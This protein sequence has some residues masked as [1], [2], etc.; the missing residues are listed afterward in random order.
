[1]KYAAG[2]IGRVFLVRFE[3]GDDLIEKIKELAAKER[4]SLASITL[5]GALK[6]GELVTGPKELVTPADANWSGFGDGREV[7]AFG[8]IVPGEKGI[9][10]HLHGAFG[11]GGE[12]LTGC[13]RKNAEVFIT[14]DCIVTEIDGINV[15]KKKEASTGH[16]VLTFE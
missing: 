16:E 6:N 5:L 8:L 14:I 9:K 7:L 13:L 3:H 1:M 15:V 11:R 2:N 12:T 10:L 4:I